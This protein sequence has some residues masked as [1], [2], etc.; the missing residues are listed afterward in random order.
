[1]LIIHN[2]KLMDL[3]R[4]LKVQKDLEKVLALVLGQIP[5]CQ[6]DLVPLVE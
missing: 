1:M 6:G 4:T 3:E 2:R 5:T